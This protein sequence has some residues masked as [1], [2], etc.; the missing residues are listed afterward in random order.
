MRTRSTLR[1]AAAIAFSSLALTGVALASEPVSVP[2]QYKGQ[3]IQLT[4]RFDK[5]AGAAPFPAVILLHGCTGYSFH[6]PH[7][8]AWS[9]VLLGEGY[10]TIILDSFT[11]RGGES[12]G[13]VPASTRALD[14]VAAA[15]FLASRPD[16]R[17]DKIA[18]MGFSHGGGTALDAAVMMGEWRNGAPHGPLVDAAVDSFG[19]AYVDE[20]QRQFK[21]AADQL[22]TRGKIAAYIA[23][24]PHT[25]KAVQGDRFAGPVLLLIGSYDEEVSYPNCEKL[26]AMQQPG[27]PEFRFKP[28]AYAS[29]SFDWDVGYT[30]TNRRPGLEQPNRSAAA[31]AREEV[32][33]FLRRYLK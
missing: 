20:L 8:S 1:F 25:C 19:A 11:P 6:L 14:V 15:Y 7:S 17:R 27:G 30:A 4:G 22:S 21:I 3:Q 28:Y 23:L 26:A 5:P 24:Y 10:A 33:S 12:C 18:V 32:T 16:I 13:G 31:D 2:V 29:H 9:A